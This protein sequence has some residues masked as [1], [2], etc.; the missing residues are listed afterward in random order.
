M[1][2][3][4]KAVNSSQGKSTQSQ[5]GTK[6]TGNTGTTKSTGGTH[7]TGTQSSSGTANRTA[8]PVRWQPARNTTININIH[9][10]ANVPIP[11][12]SC[13]ST[14]GKLLGSRASMEERLDQRQR[15]CPATDRIRRRSRKLPV[16]GTPTATRKA[17]G[18]PGK[19]TTLNATAN[20]TLHRG[21]QGREPQVR[22]PQPECCSSGTNSRRS[23]KAGNPQGGK[24]CRRPA[25]RWHYP[26][27]PERE[28]QQGHERSP[29]ATRPTT[30]VNNQALLQHA[31]AARR[32]S[33]QPSRL[34]SFP[35][36][37]QSAP[38]QS[39]PQVARRK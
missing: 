6:S 39:A 10:T 34:R 29:M 1:E 12:R 27:R 35:P 25:S 9:A 33:V 4:H 24:R 15:E 2:A 36:P 26:R 16:P 31:H 17:T 30:H 28:R 14:M 20:G 37:R 21:R 38:R 8:L 11:R 5:S 23:A 19:N 18:T 13:R 22:P 32:T 3:M 7:G